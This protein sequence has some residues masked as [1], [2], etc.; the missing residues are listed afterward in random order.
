MTPSSTFSVLQLRDLH[1]WY[2]DVHALQGIDFDLQKG[3]IHAVIGER[4]AG[5]SSLLRLL[6]GEAKK[7]DG[8]ILLDGH[9]IPYFTPESSF[10]HGIGIV[11][12]TPDL[13]PALTVMENIF[14]GRKPRS[15]LKPQLFPSLR[16]Q[17]REIFARLCF[18]LDISR[19]AENLTNKEKEMV[20]FARAFLFH[21]RIMILDEIS[22]RLNSNELDN[23]FHILVELKQSGKAIIYIANNL[24]EVM[25]IADR[26]TVLKD[27]RRRGTEPVQNMDRFRILTLNNNFIFN[28]SED[29]KAEKVL[30]LIELFNETLIND[31]P[32][33][34]ITL[35]PTF[36]VSMMNWSAHKILDL[37]EKETRGL[38]L[39]RVL[40]SANAT[41]VGEIVSRIRNHERHSWKNLKLG[42]DKYIKLKIFP[43]RDENSS[44]IGS[45]LMFE[46]VSMDHFVKEY[47]LRAEKITSV[48]ELAAG[49]AHEINNP[50]GI[51]KNHVVLLRAMDVG[52][53]ADE[54][55]TKIEKELGRIV[56]AI[57]SLLSYSRL[58][59][60]PIRSIELTSLINET[61]LLLG[62]MLRDKNINFSCTSGG[63]KIHIRADENKL[64]QLMINLIVNSIEAVTSLGTIAVHVDQDVAFGEA[65]ITVTDNG[66]G[67][68]P[69]LATDVF[70]PFFTTKMNK[71]NIGLGLSICQNIVES[72]G[73]TIVFDS[74]P[75]RM[76]TF[77]VRL[78]V[79]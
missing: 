62:H 32:L 38:D 16:A 37:R 73:G 47:L 60:N 7:T 19:L 34:I 79:S 20:E 64:K 41:K 35:T 65:I 10:R 48:A 61:S 39:E 9:E 66:F 26:V 5:K 15:F 75:G 58:Q 59:Q 76:T 1:L 28:M 4:R 57:G 13:V 22:P 51:I 46:D 31:L 27:G 55:L 45:I 36:Q 43:L 30:S 52:E 25:Q 53:E 67:I 74:K 49:V 56:E 69:E 68:P 40:S 78:P 42:S 6:G 50:L 8:S 72:H 77:T 14:L 63:E 33:G 11:H 18:D 29:E 17:C 44:Y 21:P 71:K 3:E 2:K 54:S 70:M 24:D 23:I 12:Q